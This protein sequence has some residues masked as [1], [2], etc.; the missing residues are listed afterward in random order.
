MTQLIHSPLLLWSFSCHLQSPRQKHKCRTQAPF[1]LTGGSSHHNG[2]WWGKVVYVSNYKN[3]LVIKSTICPS[4]CLPNSH[5]LALSWAQECAMTVFGG[6]TQGRGWYLLQPVWWGWSGAG[7]WFQY[8]HVSLASWLLITWRKVCL[9]EDQGG[10]QARGY[11]WL[12]LRMMLSTWPTFP[13]F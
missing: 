10:A 2:M 3:T 9:E 6:W 1:L 11:I 12:A 13:H 5:P 7:G 4:P 8:G